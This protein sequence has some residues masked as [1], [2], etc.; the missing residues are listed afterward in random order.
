MDQSGGAIAPPVILQQ[1]S[2]VMFRDRVPEVQHFPQYFLEDDMD[3]EDDETKD[4]AYDILG[5][6]EEDSNISEDD[7]VAEDSTIIYLI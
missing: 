5:E 2:Q 3:D 1:P 4:E 7:E 6:D